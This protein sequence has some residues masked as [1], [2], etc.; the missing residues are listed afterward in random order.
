[1]LNNFLHSEVCPEMKTIEQIFFIDGHS[2]TKCDECL[3]SLQNHSK[4]P[5]EIWSLSHWLTQKSEDPNIS[6]I[7]M[8]SEHFLSSLPV[9]K[10]IHS[11]KISDD[12]R[13]IEWSTFG[14]IQFEKETPFGFRIATYK[15]INKPLLNVNFLKRNIDAKIGGTL[16]ILY[17]NGRP[18]TKKKFNDLQS[19]LEYI[20]PDFHALYNELKYR[21]DDDDRDYALSTSDK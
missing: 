12:N 17:P 15:S 6:F 21:D 18:I 4:K 10:L 14:K 9:E 8:R 19:L 3:N 11:L 20:P 7:E 5:D 16:P 13:K 1:M 2:F